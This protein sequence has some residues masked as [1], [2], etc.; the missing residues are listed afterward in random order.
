[1]PPGRWGSRQRRCP[2]ALPLVGTIGLLASIAAILI[3]FVPPSQYGT[4][5][6]AQYALTLLVG[7]LVLAVP[8]QIIFMLKRP[9]WKVPSEAPGNE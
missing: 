3:A 2:G 8:P 5:P 7:V 1:V 9:R 6:V 4:K